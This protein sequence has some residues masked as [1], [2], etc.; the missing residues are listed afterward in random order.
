MWIEQYPNSKRSDVII[1]QISSF[2]L[3]SCAPA[4]DY[5]IFEDIKQKEA[6]FLRIKEETHSY[7]AVHLL[8][9]TRLLADVCLIDVFSY[10]L[11]SNSLLLC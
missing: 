9:L 6:S 8:S 2:Y 10:S 3:K 5:S 4:H 1:H 7:S 11:N